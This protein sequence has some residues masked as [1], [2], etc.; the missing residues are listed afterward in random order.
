MVPLFVLWRLALIIPLSQS[1]STTLSFSLP[2]HFPIPLSLL[3]PGCLSRLVD[4]PSGRLA[5][6]RR[7]R[8]LFRRWGLPS[9]S[10]MMKDEAGGRERETHKNMRGRKTEIMFF[11]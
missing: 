7:R 9:S 1:F 8:L 2:L 11:C 10:E 5:R 3:S 4:P 6:L